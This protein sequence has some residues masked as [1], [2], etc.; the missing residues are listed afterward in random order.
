MWKGVMGGIVNVY[1]AY[2]NAG[3][4]VLAYIRR[5]LFPSTGNDGYVSV[6]FVCMSMLVHSTGLYW[7][8]G[9][10][11]GVVLSIPVYW[12]IGISTIERTAL[13]GMVDWRN[14]IR[15]GHSL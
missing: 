1:F 4:N 8:L 11:G 6:D 5:C 2:R 13:L 10:A 15:K 7:I 9:L 14:R 3:L 12:R